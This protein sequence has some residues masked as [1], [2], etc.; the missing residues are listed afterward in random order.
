MIKENRYVL[1][2]FVCTCLLALFA[3]FNAYCMKTYNVLIQENQIISPVLEDGEISQNKSQSE[4]TAESQKVHPSG[5]DEVIEGLTRQEWL[6]EINNV[7]KLPPYTVLNG[8]FLKTIT[9]V[10][11]LYEHIVS[12]CMY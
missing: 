6:L 1:C 2:F 9:V 8:L 7:T 3:C 12:K 5:G 10:W 11:V 4:P